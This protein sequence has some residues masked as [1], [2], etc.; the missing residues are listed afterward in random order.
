MLTD[1]VGFIYKRLWFQG[2]E[3]D[4]DAWQKGNAAMPLWLSR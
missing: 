2:F 1:G 3:G 4:F